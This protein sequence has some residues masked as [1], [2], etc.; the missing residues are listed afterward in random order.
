MEQ[1]YDRIL[2]MNRDIFFPTTI[3]D[4]FFENP[5]AIRNFALKQRFSTDPT[6]SY[7]GKRTDQIHNINPIFFNGVIKKIYNLFYK[8]EEQDVFFNCQAYFQLVD[9]SYGSGWIHKDDPQML[10]VIVYLTPNTA[11]GTSLYTKK[12]CLVDGNILLHKKEEAY[13]KQTKDNDSCQ[14]NNSLYEETINIKGLYNRM[15]LFDSIKFHGAH[16]FCGDSEDKARLTLVMFFKK[17]DVASDYY[18]IAK[19]NMGYYPTIL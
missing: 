8:V 10:T 1:I 7:P 12:D 2:V 16:N 4:G 14:K 5:D 13:K 6:N 3:V 15:V 11:D 19:M 9:G 18:P 17:L